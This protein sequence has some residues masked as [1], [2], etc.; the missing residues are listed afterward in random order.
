[1]A[2]RLAEPMVDEMVVK[3]AELWVFEWVDL[4]VGYWVGRR[5]VESVG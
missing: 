1:M 5:V 4:L 3:M 2:G